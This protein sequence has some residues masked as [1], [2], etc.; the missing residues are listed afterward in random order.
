MLLLLGLVSWFTYFQVALL[1]LSMY[2][3]LIKPGEH[4]A[5]LEEQKE[6]T[7]KVERAAKIAR[8]M[9]EHAEHGH[10]VAGTDQLRDWFMDQITLAEYLL[11]RVEDPAYSEEIAHL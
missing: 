3:C 6:N 4:K 8:A 1:V 5:E 7:M 11:E 2:G 10:R 9:I